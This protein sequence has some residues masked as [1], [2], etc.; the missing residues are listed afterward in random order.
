MLKVSVISLWRFVTASFSL[1]SRWSD[2]VGSKGGRGFQV[3]LGVIVLTEV[4]HHRGT[5]GWS[6]WDLRSSVRATLRGDS[7]GSLTG[8]GDPK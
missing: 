3:G 4:V 6:L 7:D 5:G 1:W 2:I 8:R